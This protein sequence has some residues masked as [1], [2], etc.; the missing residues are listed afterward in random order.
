MT[1]SERLR[2]PWNCFQTEEEHMLAV[3]TSEGE[4]KI[5]KNSLTW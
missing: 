1:S 3:T 4:A 2:V 5:P